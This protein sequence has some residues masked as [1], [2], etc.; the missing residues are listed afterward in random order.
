MLRIQNGMKI[1]NKY[2]V[3]L[4]TIAV[5]LIPALSF[6]TSD[7]VKNDDDYK[8]YVDLIDKM[9]KKMVIKRTVEVQRNQIREYGSSMDEYTTVIGLIG[10]QFG[11]IQ[12]TKFDIDS[13]IDDVNEERVKSGKEMISRNK[14]LSN[15]KEGSDYYKSQINMICSNPSTRA[16]VDHD[17]EYKYKNFDKNM[18][19]ISVIRV[20]KAKCIE[21]E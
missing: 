14:L 13:M 2:L 19:L 20:D 16:L 1:I 6:A 9:G 5:Y 21:V 11:F 12:T 17:I 4:F 7:A 3:I 18:N 8:K 10:N 15:F